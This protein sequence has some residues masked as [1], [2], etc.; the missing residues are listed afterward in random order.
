MEVRSAPGQAISP[1]YSPIV[2]NFRRA[3]RNSLRDIRKVQYRGRLTGV[4]LASHRKRSN[5]GKGVTH[6]FM[7]G[8][9][10]RVMAIIGKGC[11]STPE[12]PLT[13]PSCQIPLRL[14]A[15][16]RSSSPTPSNQEM[17][18]SDVVL[19]RC[20][21][22]RLHRLPRKRPRSSEPRTARRASRMSSVEYETD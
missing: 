10:S 18:V 22:M 14:R 15:P 3:S 4:A 7:I 13:F 20:A 6:D 21:P 5:S 17:V 11:A 8:S 2:K 1:M 12:L 19:R 9:V 16:R